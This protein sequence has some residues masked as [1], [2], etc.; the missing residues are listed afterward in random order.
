MLRCVRRLPETIVER[1][2]G[3][4][5]STTKELAEGSLDLPTGLAEERED[6]HMEQLF[7]DFGCA[8]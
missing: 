2:E 7:D 4:A 6:V 5:D 8:D 1:A 3:R